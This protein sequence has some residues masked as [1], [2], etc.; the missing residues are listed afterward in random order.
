MQRWPMQ[1]GSLRFPTQHG[2]DMKP[3]RRRVCR[4]AVAEWR[5]GTENNPANKPPQSKNCNCPACLLYLKTNPPQ[6]PK[7]RAKAKPTP[8]KQ[9]PPKQQSSKQQPWGH[10]PEKLT[11]SSGVPKKKKHVRRLGHRA[12]NKF[13]WVLQS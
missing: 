12:T 7:P 5:A 2:I 8:S 10:S 13:V 1:R 4:A 11:S 9:Q 3:N 6:P